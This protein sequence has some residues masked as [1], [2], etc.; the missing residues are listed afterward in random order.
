M[1]RHPKAETYLFIIKKENLL[2]LNM[3]PINFAFNETLT[4]GYPLIIFIFYSE[5]SRVILIKI[6]QLLKE[7]QDYLREELSSK[8]PFFR[9]YEHT[10]DIKDATFINLN[11]YPLSP[12]Y[13]KE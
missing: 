3:K 8:L 5:T 13:L 9:D 12:I 1:L 4:R 7:F 11:F 10:I 2:K 6:E